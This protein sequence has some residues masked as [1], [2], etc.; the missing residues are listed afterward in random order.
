MKIFGYELYK[1]VKAKMFWGITAV[2]LA[3]SLFVFG[4][5]QNKITGYAES[6]DIFED[7]IQHWNGTI[8]FGRCAKY[9]IF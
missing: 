9:K 6:K 7:L 3:F 8:Y 4:M 2:L 1:I 5:Q